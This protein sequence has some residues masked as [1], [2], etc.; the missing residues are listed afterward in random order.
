L[1]RLATLAWAAFG[2]AALTLLLS[3]GQYGVL[4]WLPDWLPLARI[5]RF[6]CRYLVLFQFAGAVLAAIGFM[7]LTGESRCARQLRRQGLLYRERHRLLALWRNFEPL[8]CVVGA[9]AAVAG[10]GVA[11]RHDPYIASVPA[12]LAGPLLALAAIALVIVAARGY[13][14]ALVGLVV[15]AAL[16]QG[17]YGLGGAVYPQSADLP[18][19]VASARTP[20]GIPDGRLVGSLLRF[21]QPGLRT[22]DLVTLAGWRRADG[23]AG[24]EPRQ[25]LD[26]HLLPALRVAGVRW[27]QRGPSTFGVAGLKPYD[28]RWSEVP[29]PLPR[30]RLVTQTKTS[31]DPDIDVARVHPDATALTDVPLALP[32]S[33]PG[34]AALVAERPGRLEVAVDCPARQLLV[35]AESYHHGW[36]ATIDGQSQE[37]Y[38]VN[39]D[40][41]GCPVDQGKHVVVFDFHP[42]SLE[43]GWFASYLGLGFLSLCFLGFSARPRPSIMK[44]DPP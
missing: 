28:D 16:D 6:P 21:D 7:L 31:R 38:R 41:L 34:R 19:F 17:C 22:G 8:W 26:Y 27:V 24:L 23:Y 5:F 1:G 4:D 3:F 39:G 25:R 35:V 40:F 12:I 20:P 36:L 14:S 18:N 2:F 33:A 11:W 37:I 10:I 15:L 29:N 42:E 32:A 43:R 9:S 13:P 44:D 30:V